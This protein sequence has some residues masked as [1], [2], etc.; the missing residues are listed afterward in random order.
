M[1][2][3]CRGNDYLIDRAAAVSARPPAA[4]RLGDASAAGVPASGFLPLPTAAAAE[5]NTSPA[6]RCFR[7]CACRTAATPCGISGLATTA[8]SAGAGLFRGAPAAARAFA[9]ARLPPLRPAVAAPQVGT[10][11]IGARRAAPGATTSLL[12]RR[13]PPQGPPAA[14]GRC[15]AVVGP[16]P[17][18]RP[19]RSCRRPGARGPASGRLGRRRHGRGQRR[20]GDRGPAPSR[21]IGSGAPGLAEEQAAL[22]TPPRPPE[23]AARRPRACQ[24]APPWP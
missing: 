20:L 4:L 22:V 10:Q 5:G 6:A 3:S 18:R 23:P 19:R 12:Q 2:E 13:L 8:Q 16:A 21:S 11:A 9:T 24:T 15:V 17:C 7:S 14:A 1:G